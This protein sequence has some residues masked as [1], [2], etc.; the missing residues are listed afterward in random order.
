MTVNQDI[1]MTEQLFITKRRIHRPH[2]TPTADSSTLVGKKI[3]F[4]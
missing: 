3:S 4:V 2:V 1:F